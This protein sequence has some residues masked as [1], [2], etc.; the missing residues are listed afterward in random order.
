MRVLILVA[1][2]TQK[3]TSSTDGM[4]RSVATSPLLAHRASAVVE[5]RMLQMEKALNDRD[6]KS[7]AELTMMDSNQFHACC[8][9]TYPPIFY[10]NET[11]KHVIDT[12]TSLN[13]VSKDGPIAAY[14]FDAGPNAVVYT[15]EKDMHK[16]LA[17]FE[18]LYTNGSDSFVFDP[19]SLAT[20]RGSVQVEESW[21]SSV[22]PAG[23]NTKIHQIIVS[24]VGEGAQITGRSHTF[25]Q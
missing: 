16:L 11:S 20:Q 9:D 23:A 14:T 13:A 1:N 10:M 2:A 17:V 15:L 22:K 4:Q 5:P 24:K 8:L 12:I 7:F 3:E 21:S 25:G 19:M 6:F 18:K